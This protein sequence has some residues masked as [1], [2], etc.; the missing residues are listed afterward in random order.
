MDEWLLK[1]SRRVGINKCFNLLFIFQ[2]ASYNIGSSVINNR[3]YSAGE[4]FV[5]GFRLKSDS[6]YNKQNGNKNLESFGIMKDASRSQR[7]VI[8]HLEDEKLEAPNTSSQGK[9]MLYIY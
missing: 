4:Y 6:E 9:S 8:Q 3:R 1:H 7:S 5:Q 2:T